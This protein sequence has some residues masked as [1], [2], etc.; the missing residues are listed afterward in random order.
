[1]ARR[2]RGSQSK[3]Q[4]TQETPRSPEQ[5]QGIPGT[6]RLL[7]KKGLGNG[8][9]AWSGPLTLEDGKR[10][11]MEGTSS[12]EHGF[13]IKVMEPVARNWKQVG[14]FKIPLFGDKRA[15][16]DVTLPQLGINVKIWPGVTRENQTC[17]KLQIL[18]AQGRPANIAM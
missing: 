11:V 12:V 14:G 3:Q 8:Y 6:G 16:R 10:L 7:F 5:F 1:M 18:N 4:L 13:E 15:A 2:N 9:F 17:L